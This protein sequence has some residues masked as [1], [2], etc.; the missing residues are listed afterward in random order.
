MPNSHPETRV[1]KQILLPLATAFLA[2]LGFTISQ[3]IWMQQGNLDTTIRTHLSSAK[4]IFADE[5]ARDAAFISC[6]LDFYEQNNELQQAFLA[7]DRER[8]L[9]AVAPIF[10]T[11][12]DNYQLTHF[13]FINADHTCFLRA[14]QPDLYGDTIPRPTLLHAARQNTTVHGLELGPLGTLTLRV[15]RPW[16]I[17]GK[18]AGSLEIGRDLPHILQKLRKVLG[19]HLVA[20]VNTAAMAAVAMD[21]TIDAAPRRHLVIAKTLDQIPPELGQRIVAGPGDRQEIFSVRMDDQKYRCSTID[22]T[23]LDGNNIGNIYILENFT[24]AEATLHRTTLIVV[25]GALLLGLL[26]FLFFYNRIGRME[27]HLRATTDS[28]RVKTD[29]YKRAQEAVQASANRYQSLVDTIPHGVQECDPDGIITFSN[30]AHHRILGHAD[31][32]LIGKAIWELHADEEDQQQLRDYLA[33]LVKEQPAPSP[34]YARNR[35]KDGRLIDVEVNWDYQRNQDGQLTGF[36]AI[37]TDITERHRAEES[38][39]ESED[40]YRD[41]I[42]TASDLVQMVRPDGKIFYANRAWRETLGYTEAEAQN[43]TILD[44]I[45]PQCREIC[46][47]NF[48]RVLTEGSV[49]KMEATFVAK[50]GRRVLGGNRQLPLPRRRAQPDPLHFQGRYRKTGGG[51]APDAGAEARLPGSAG[52]RHRP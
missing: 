6:Q 2:L 26:I 8:L 52:G 22:L 36:I 31:G 48:E 21:Q 37:I 41:F 9:T 46:L 16:R 51:A 24:A 44:I 18:R 14:H 49:D 29:Q 34:Y 33:Y 42:E 30:P 40:R 35:T 5:L 12:R 38:L 27:K 43:L 17:N 47:A 50:D 20:S 25:A 7:G 15:V 3:L 32:E 23:D 1:K 11:I 4:T 10:Q 28:L 39:R 13:Y 19:V 45:D